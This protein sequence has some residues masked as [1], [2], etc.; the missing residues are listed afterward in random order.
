MHHLIF[1]ARLVNFFMSLFTD[2]GYGYGLS[3]SLKGT[4]ESMGAPVVWDMMVVRNRSYYNWSFQLPA[5]SSNSLTNLPIPTS[6]SYV[7]PLSCPDHAW[8]WPQLQFWSYTWRLL[9]RDWYMWFWPVWWFT[10]SWL[11]YHHVILPS[12]FVS[13]FFFVWTRIS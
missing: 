5:Y 3:A 4:Y 1:S 13:R 7:P 12:V 9:S 11:C 6:F 10:P 2:S 8:N